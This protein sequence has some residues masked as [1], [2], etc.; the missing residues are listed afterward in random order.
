MLGLLNLGSLV[1]GMIAWILPIIDLVQ[2]SKASHRRCAVFSVSSVSACAIS[3]CLQIFEMNHRVNIQ[4]WAALLDTSY[5]VASVAT[6][7]LAGTV[8]LNAITL[9]VHYRKRLRD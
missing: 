1:F 6:L 2:H 5:S 3:L 8:I 4:D 9:V 7:L